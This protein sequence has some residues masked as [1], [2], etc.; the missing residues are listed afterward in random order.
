M[1]KTENRESKTAVKRPANA[2]P[3]PVPAGQAPSATAFLIQWLFS[4]TVRHATAMRKHVQK[5]VNHQR[6]VLSAQAIDA[7]EASLAELK[8]AVD[9]QADREALEKQ[10]GKLEE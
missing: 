3:D 4:G 10:M 5:L 6:D 2:A 1:A 8:S 7:I 9:R